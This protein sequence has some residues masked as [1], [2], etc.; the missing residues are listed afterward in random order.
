MPSIS[1]YLPALGTLGGL[2][3]GTFTQSTIPVCLTRQDTLIPELNSAKQFMIKSGFWL[4]IPAVLFLVNA[5]V[6]ACKD[7]TN[8]P[9]H[10]KIYKALTNQF[11]RKEALYSAVLLTGALSHSSY[12]TSFGLRPEKGIPAYAEGVKAF[13]SSGHTML[14]IAALPIISKL[15]GNMAKY[16]APIAFTLSAAYAASDA[17][18]LYNTSAIEQNHT[19]EEVAAGILWAGALSATA[20]L[21]SSLVIS[22]MERLYPPQKPKQ[23]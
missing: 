15:F 14:S 18:F 21:T 5:S 8:K 1:S 6:E 3:A 7:Q 11:T 23:Q 9:A 13:K 10:K 20:E 19:V 2:A 16:A 12:A 17:V 4:A 22:A